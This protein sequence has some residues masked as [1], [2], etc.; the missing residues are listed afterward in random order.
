[1]QVLLAVDVI[2]GAKR[3]VARVLE[4]SAGGLRIE[5]S[6]AF[7]D[8]D[9]VE[10][11]RGDISIAGR[12]AWRSGRIMGI[13]FDK[14]IDEHAFLRFRNPRHLCPSCDRPV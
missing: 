14:E 2:A 8:E 13:A 1:M 12:V 5:V 7:G 10:V 9:R 6:A 3:E 4:I 11:R